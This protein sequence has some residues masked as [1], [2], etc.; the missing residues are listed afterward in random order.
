MPVCLWAVL[1]IINVSSELNKYYNKS[2]YENHILI[3]EGST[4]IA[5]KFK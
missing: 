5:L 3:I 1:K 4:D 2:K